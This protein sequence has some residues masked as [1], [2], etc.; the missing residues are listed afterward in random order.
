MSPITVI[1][2]EK[3]FSV[4]PTYKY[5]PDLSWSGENDMASIRCQGITLPLTDESPRFLYFPHHNPF[6]N[7]SIAFTFFVLPSRIV[8]GVISNSFN[9]PHRPFVGRY[10]LRRD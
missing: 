1:S 5:A 9:K 2:N 3:R 10:R 4:L 8:C 7:D 6:G